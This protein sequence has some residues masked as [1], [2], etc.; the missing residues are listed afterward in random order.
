MAPAERVIA[1]VAGFDP[2]SDDAFV[3]RL[4]IPGLRRAGDLRTALRSV[5]RS[6]VVHATGNGSWA[7][8]TRVESRRLSAAEIVTLAR[9]R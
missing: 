2:A 9:G 3:D 8:G 6:T 5:G 4:Y 1:D 7:D